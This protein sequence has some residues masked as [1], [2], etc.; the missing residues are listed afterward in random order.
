M[1]IQTSTNDTY[2]ER[3]ATVLDDNSPYTAMFWIK[4]T[5]NPSTYQQPFQIGGP[6]I[7]DKVSDSFG[8][9]SDGITARLLVAD[10]TNATATTDGTITIGAWTHIAIVRISTTQLKVYINGVDAA[11]DNTRDVSA[12]AAATYMILLNYNQFPLVGLQ[13]DVRYFTSALTAAEIQQEMKSPTVVN[14]ATLWA[15][16]PCKGASVTAALT[17]DSGN[18]RDFSTV[19]G[20]GAITVSSDEPTYTVNLALSPSTLPGGTVGTAYSETITASGGTAPYSFAVTAGSLPP[21]LSLSSGGVLSGTPTTAGSYSFTISATDSNSNTGSQAYSG[22]TIGAATLAVSPPSLPGAPLNVPFS[23]SLTA[24]GGIAP[25]TFSLSSGSL[26]AGLSLGSGGGLSGTPTEVGSFTFTVKVTDAASDTATVTYSQFVVTTAPAVYSVSSTSAKT[27]ST[28][29]TLPVQPVGIQTFQATLGTQDCT[30][31]L[32]QRSTGLFIDL[33][34]A[35]AVVLSSRYCRDR[36]NL[37]RRA[38]LGFAGWLYFVDTSG[39]G[40][41]PSYDGLGSRWLLVYES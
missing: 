9:D 14:T 28:Q 34:V 18:G 31:T 17:D 12:R 16:I 20:T 29:Q 30:I 3:T 24:S 22:V 39:A 2:V 11:M 32:T 13:S 6:F 38:Y 5:S 21:G 23:A 1:S 35:G 7:Y 10:G 26:P 33:S 4:S 37:V 27:P 15:H 40:A 19:I 36:V 8:T 25:Y 41:D